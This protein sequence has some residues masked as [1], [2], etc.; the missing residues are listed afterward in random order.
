[1]ARL[2]ASTETEAKLDAWVGF[3]LPDLDG[4]VDG[5]LG[6][7]RPERSL[8]AVYYDTRDLRLARAGI[9]VRHRTGEGDGDGTWTVKLPEGA[10]GPAT[11]RREVTLVAP[12]RV[13]PDEVA[14]LV[15]A[16]VRSAVL[17]PVARLRTRRRSIELRD[18]DGQPLAEIADDEVSVMDGPRLAARFR[19]LEVELRA[20]SPVGLLAGVVDRLCRAGASPAGSTPKLLRALGPRA[21]QP[22]DAAVPPL[23]AAATMADVVRAAVAS[24]TTRLVAHDPGVRLG[25]DAEDVHQARVAVRRLRSDLRTFRPVL[26]AEATAAL[27]EDLRELAADLGEV[28]DA[29]VLLD[30]LRGQSAELPGADPAAVAGLLD[31]LA[32]RREEARER[33]LTV[34]DGDTYVALLDRL[35]VAS[36]TPPCLPE[37]GEP[38]GRVLR[39]IVRRPWAHLRSAVDKLADDPPVD[40]LHEIRIRAKRCRYAAE[41]AAPVVGRPA[42]RFARA[43]AEVQGV[44]GD[45][46]D[47][48]VAE[49]WLRDIGPSLPAAQALLAGE[50]VGVQRR[51]VED[52]RRLWRGAW[53]AASDKSLRAW[54]R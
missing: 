43:V 17:A 10:A 15:R 54:L 44:L 2:A 41:A 26:D 35:V 32:A 5:A 38:A 50:L 9:T 27:R 24:G 29:D 46:N 21:R 36:A 42:R 14:G 1:M 18:A 19:E 37:A 53:D 49:A 4:V 3:R 11:T 22:P 23:D 12:G 13:I 20:G 28:R 40:D 47:A 7:P 45:L 51:A 31:R 34:L 52:G 30:R 39:G 16:A 6:V 48:V 33:L 25:E 8:D